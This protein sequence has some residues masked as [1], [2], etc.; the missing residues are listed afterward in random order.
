MAGK[1]SLKLAI[2]LTMAEDGSVSIADWK[3][4]RSINQ[5][6]PDPKCLADGIEQACRRLLDIVGDLRELQAEK[7]A[8]GG[9]P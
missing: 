3:V 7:A 9:T 1:R 8:L 5:V 6:N 4:S 2:D